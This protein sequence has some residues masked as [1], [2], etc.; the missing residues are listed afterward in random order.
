MPKLKLAILD[1]YEGTPNQG[2][3]CIYEILNNYQEIIEHETF[4]V[5]CKAAVPNL[6]FDIYISSGGPGDP[7]EGDGD[8][9]AKYYAWL[10]SVWKYNQNP[11][12]NKKKYVFFICHS[13][14]M[15]CIHFKVADITP[16][17]SM[18]FG[19]FPVYPTDAGE[20]DPIFERLDNPFYIAD[21][22]RFQVIQPDKERFDSMG[23]E[24]LALEKPRPNIPLERAI[25][26]IRFS[27]EM[28]GTQFHPEADGDGMLVWLKEEEKK[29]QIISEHGLEKYEQMFVD[30]S[31][32][33]KIE[34][35]QN[36]VLPSFL[37][38][39]IEALIEEAAYV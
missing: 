37:N 14:Q 8:W 15:A 27:E 16:R 7:R 12:N 32:P 18:S 19:T 39:A 9:D 20:R 36:T 10:E 21:F 35:T 5:R 34:K 25:M 1:L 22:R 28:F 24:I 38:F 23:A 3:R 33:N 17:K 31:D 2:M 29:Q 6:D 4:D 11:A 30:L 13:F 26:A